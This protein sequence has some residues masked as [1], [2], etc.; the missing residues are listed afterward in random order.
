MAI[1]LFAENGYFYWRDRRE[2][3]QSVCYQRPMVQRGKKPMGS[4]LR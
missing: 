1:A 4:E 3:A 2:R